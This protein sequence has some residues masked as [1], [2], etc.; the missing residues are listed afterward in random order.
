MWYT[1]MS[2]DEVQ[3]ARFKI[4]DAGHYKHAK[5]FS[6]ENHISTAGKKGVKLSVVVHLPNGNTVKVDGFLTS[7]ASMEF[8]TRHLAE[9]LDLLNEYEAG[10]LTVE[11]ML[12][13][14]DIWLKGGVDIG[15]QKA[16]PKTDGS[17]EFWNERNNI[18]DFG[19]GERDK[20]RAKSHL[21]QAKA[22]LETVTT[23]RVLNKPPVD[24]FDDSIPF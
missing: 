16:K 1:P 21:S 19:S 9:S 24:E 18:L 15:I 22:K 5:L 4:I 10:S 17:G 13:K 23:G 6:A 12:K 7:H 11:S 20:S 3:K 2:E 14:R 8:L